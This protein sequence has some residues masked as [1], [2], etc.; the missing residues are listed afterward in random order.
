MT[1]AV[2]PP[3]SA[4]TD[5]EP[6]DFIRA[7]VRGDVAAGKHG[8]RVATRFPPEPNGYLHIG[9]A[10]SICLNFGVAAE[11]GGTCNLRFD[12]TN[13]ETESPEYVEAI[14]ADVRWLGFDWEERLYFASD[15]F[16]QLYD[17]AVKLIEGGKA[18]VD[19]LSEEE[20]RAY[21][22]TVTEPGRP[23]P[24]RGRSVAENLDLF[25]RM[26][27]G[28]FDEGEHVLRGRIDMAAANMLMRDPLLYR[29]RK[30]PHYRRG[31]EWCIFPLYDFTHCLSDSFESITHSLCTLEFE[32]NRE[33]YD[34]VIR[35]TSVPWQPQQIE[36]A[37][38][39]LSYTVLSKRKL[40]R[41]VNEGHV[42]GWD[43]PRMP[44]ISG[45]RRR[46][47]TPAAIRGFC[48]RIG[49][50]KSYNVIDVAL[51][52]YSLRDDLN[53]QA[54]RVL[55]V[56]RPLRVVIENY[57]EDLVEELEAPYY[58]HDVP[59]EG[60][61]KL[62]FSR[63]IYVERDDFTEDPPPGYHRLA[64]GRE[65]RLRYAYLVRCE[66]VVRNGDGEV[67]Q[68]VCSYDPET[69]GGNAPDG[70]TVKGTLHWVSA[71]HSLS[72]EVR[73]YDRLFTSEKP[74]EGEDFRQDLNPG[75]LEV[76]SES[77]IEPSVAGARPYDRFQLER[78]GYFCV[79]AVDSRPDRLVL[80]RT[81]TLRDTWAK[82]ARKQAGETA[83]EAAREKAARKAEAKERQRQVT[84]RERPQLDPQQ[85]AAVERYRGLG[86]GGEDARTLAV[87]PALQAFFEDALRGPGAPPAV[88][89]W[90]VN[91]LRRELKESSIAD[92][93]FGGVALSE[94]VALV[95]AG[96][97]TGAVGKKVF[98][99][100][101]ATGDR[102]RQIVERR[103]LEQVGD[104]GELA[105]VVARVLAAEAD[106]VAAYRAGKTA[107]MGHFV[108]Q[109]MK[110]TRGRANPRLVQEL[111]RDELA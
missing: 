67:T 64:P 42:A 85:Q 34:W 63:V 8:G 100:M 53:T 58:P 14:Q 57:P 89:S 1:T 52:E 104:A 45:L 37:R 80:N 59:R 17:C 71:E 23:S 69:R 102:P 99:E 11:L 38:L 32:N 110:A 3:A 10:K 84:A 103:G 33:L 51:L 95:D 22:G 40:L 61:R 91:E 86:V 96:T 55:C 83:G 15:Y 26:R 46:G 107:L 68:L 44:T 18:Y 76:L 77:R 12:D 79:D 29:I 6:P 28:E 60:S 48:D 90:I 56:L 19:S 25:A 21:R 41:L 81:V 50:A 47:Y 92:L 36:F 93:A 62:P 94:L 20:I 78:Q 9:H 2:K 24:Y 72:V 39:N 7:L 82:I 13:P 101:L 16:E 49:V 74:D 31:S 66:R 54:P 30:H 87:D 108:G 105:P 35:E 75:S 4:P 27:A 98:A 43:D 65:V 88:A 111:L 73:L 106:N 70:R 5:A 97:I 109:V